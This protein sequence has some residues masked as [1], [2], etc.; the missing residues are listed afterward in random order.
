MC[1]YVYVCVWV[2]VQV[3]VGI[4]MEVRGQLW[5]EI[6]RWPTLFVWNGACH[7]AWNL[8]VDHADSTMSIQRMG[9]HV[10]SHVSPLL[11][12]STLHAWISMW[13]AWIWT[14][15]SCLQ[16]KRVSDWLTFFAA[17]FVVRFFFSFWDEILLSSHS[18]PGTSCGPGWAQIHRGLL[19]L[20]SLLPGHYCL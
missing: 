11:G 10:I 5:V 1:M 8:D 2:D 6:L 12:T 16:V 14:Q 19:P 17:V 13:S 18:W 3:H 9:L 4:H 15:V 7:L 20:G